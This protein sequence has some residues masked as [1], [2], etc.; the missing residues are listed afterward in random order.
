MAVTYMNWKL[1]CVHSNHCPFIMDFE[2]CVKRIN[3]MQSTRVGQLSGVKIRIKSFSTIR[4][5]K[6]ICVATQTQ[7]NGWINRITV[8]M[9]LSI[10]ILFAWNWIEHN[11]S[12]FERKG[13][14][15][16]RVYVHQTIIRIVQ[17]STLGMPHLD[18][19][20]IRK[21]INKVK[22][23]KYMKKKHVGFQ[24]QASQ[25]KRPT[26]IPNNSNANCNF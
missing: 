16:Y 20:S 4:M 15:E 21:T 22:R 2:K 11:P 14:R 9:I 18:M 12:L 24:M 10:I 25:A 17:Y 8:Q 23:K 5:N 3:N 7:M 13:N 6:S 1:H 19:I 26:Q